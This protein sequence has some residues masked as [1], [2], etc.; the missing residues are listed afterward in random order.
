M[1]FYL[2]ECVEVHKY[3]EAKINEIRSDICN[4]IIICIIDTNIYS[5]IWRNIK[6]RLIVL[7]DTT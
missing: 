2:D 4:N 1:T 7:Q 5:V 6:Q 3:T